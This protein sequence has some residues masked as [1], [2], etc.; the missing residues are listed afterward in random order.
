M[1]I[2]TLIGSSAV[3]AMSMATASMAEEIHVAVVFTNG[4]ENAW[5]KV[6]L[7][8]SNSVKAQAPQGVELSLDYTENVSGDNLPV[9]LKISCKIRQV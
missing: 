2:L 8:G 5:A 4:V 1:K 3:L 9:V 6:S 7:I